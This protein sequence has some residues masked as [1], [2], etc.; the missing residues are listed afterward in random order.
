MTQLLNSN[1]LKE[2]I[3]QFRKRDPDDPKRC[4]GTLIDTI[5]EHLLY[6]QEL[7]NRN[8]QTRT[9]FHS[10]APQPVA[11][12]TSVCPYW[13]AGHCRNVDCPMP[14]PDGMKGTQPKGKGD[15]KGKSKG[16]N[17]PKAICA[18]FQDGSCP[19]TE[20]KCSYRHVITHDP[21]EKARLETIREQ[22]QGRARSPSPCAPKLPCRQFME[23]GAC[24]FGSLCRYTHDT[25][26]PAP[27]GQGKAKR[28]DAEA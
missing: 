10:H 11:A 13:L 22:S 3:T 18:R 7:K 12:G 28:A 25:V 8:D 5:D 6:Q 17:K 20:D 4:Y 23:T 27:K 9:M 16:K 15:G 2:Q 21:E 1:E 14:H 19:N 26:H 24:T